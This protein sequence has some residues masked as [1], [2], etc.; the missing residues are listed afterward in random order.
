M[1]EILIYAAILTICVFA[2]I[3][4]VAWLNDALE[5]INRQERDEERRRRRRAAARKVRRH[6]EIE[7]N[8]Q[9][10]NAA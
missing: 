10:R 5:E 8:I 9:R 4:V 6:R 7:Q 3:A 1:T 2:A